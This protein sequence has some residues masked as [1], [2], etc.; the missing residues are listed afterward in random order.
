MLMHT[1]TPQHPDN[2][3]QTLL[4]DYAA[5]VPNE[6]FSR[7]V[8]QS[9]DIIALQTTQR[10]TTKRRLYSLYGAAFLGG[11]FTALQLPS[12]VKLWSS[13]YTMLS[14]ASFDINSN[15]I[16]LGLFAALALWAVVDHKAPDLF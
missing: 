5:P 1:E 9:I 3:F 2:D 4:S 14:Q 12:V 11:T 15:L 10:Q 6:G 7:S 13:F 8:M 16:G